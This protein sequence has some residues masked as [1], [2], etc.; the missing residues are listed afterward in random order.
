MAARSER[1]TRSILRAIRSGASSVKKCTPATSASVVITR[2]RPVGTSRT[3]A[4]SE[5]LKTPS[6]P[7]VSGRKYL[8][9]RPNSSS[10]FAGATGNRQFARPQFAR[11]AIEHAVD[12]TGLAVGVEGIG[13]IDVFADDDARRHIG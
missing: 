13:E 6:R 8:A 7:P 3:A 12:Q 5:R 4:S 1:L 10:G 2:R 9:I 11:Q